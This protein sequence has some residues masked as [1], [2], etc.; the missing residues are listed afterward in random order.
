MVNYGIVLVALA[1]LAALAREWGD[2]GADELQRQG[3]AYVERFG[4]VG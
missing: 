4:H 2:P 3:R 1:A